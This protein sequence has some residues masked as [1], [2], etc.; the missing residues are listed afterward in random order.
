MTRI[1]FITLLV[2]LGIA[3]M[4]AQ[5]VLLDTVHFDHD[6]ASLNYLALS[7]LDAIAAATQTDAA[8]DFRIHIKAHTDSTGDVNYNNRLSLKRASTVRDYLVAKGIDSNLISLQPFGELVPVS[9]N[10]TENGRWSNRRVEIRTVIFEPEPTLAVAP[11]AAEPELEEEPFDGYY[12]GAQGTQ[13]Y[14][15]SNAFYPYRLEDVEVEIVEAMSAGS[16]IQNN[17]PTVTSDGRCLISAGSLQVLATVDGETV[18]PTNGAA[19][20]RVPADSFD[21]DM[22]L[23][24][25]DGD[26]SAN[27][28]AEN[29]ADVEF[30]ASGKAYYTFSATQ[31]TAF[32]LDK[33][34]DPVAAG[35]ALAKA[36]IPKKAFEKR[37]YTVKS[38]D[39]PLTAA[40]IISNN[41]RTVVGG[42]RVESN[43]LRFAPCALA[44]GGVMVA[45]YEYDDRVFLV[46]KPIGRIKNQRFWGRFILK[47]KDFQTVSPRKKER[48]LAKL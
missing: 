4:H 8:Q 5:K 26:I 13:V 21:E 9:S 7:G 47:R 2:F 39:M 19:Q 48:I 43:V 46:R 12:Y 18:Q 45:Y 31:L 20:I 30:D 3:P 28:W 27:G 1:T 14:F 40:Y 25:A 36:I 22:Q 23:W 35:Q 37:A 41:G 6:R 11:E 44:E 33:L 16:L 17:W 34:S 38:K 32:N 29:N 15:D 24:T 42:E 10:A